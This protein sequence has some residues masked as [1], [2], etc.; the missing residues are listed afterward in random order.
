MGHRVKIRSPHIAMER[1]HLPKVRYEAFAI[2]APFKISPQESISLRYEILGGNGKNL[3]ETVAFPPGQGLLNQTKLFGDPKDL[4][5]TER[6][7]PNPW[8]EVA[9][10]AVGSGGPMVMLMVFMGWLD[11]FRFFRRKKQP[12]QLESPS[13]EGL[14]QSLGVNPPELDPMG[15]KGSPFDV[16]ELPKYQAIAEKEGLSLDLVMARAIK[17][18]SPTEIQGWLQYRFPNDPVA[19]VRWVMRGKLGNAAPVVLH[20]LKEG[21]LNLPDK[22]IDLKDVIRF[23]WEVK[24]RE[25]LGQ[26]EKWHE[27]ILYGED[28]HPTGLTLEHLPGIAFLIGWMG[29]K[30]AAVI[31]QLEDLENGRRSKVFLDDQKLKGRGAKLKMLLRL[32]RITRS[33]EFHLAIADLM[34]F[35][36]SRSENEMHVRLIKYLNSLPPS[37]PADIKFYENALRLKTPAIRQFVR[38]KFFSQYGDTIKIIEDESRWPRSV[39]ELGN[40]IFVA[41]NYAFAKGVDGENLWEFLEDVSRFFDDLTGPQQL[42]LV[43]TYWIVHMQ[44]LKREGMEDVVFYLTKTLLTNPEVDLEAGRLFNSLKREWDKSIPKMETKNGGPYR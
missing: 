26:F 42:E 14:S 1:V 28:L 35:G 39:E 22:P 12:K 36:S 43:T 30:R 4:M 3:P 32:Q 41:K 15:N 2:D 33:L 29:G 9:M 5:P 21:F 23:F 6:T 34:R 11:F 20:Y 38:D 44:A 24:A 37:S 17:D 25:F 40:S 13:Q 8:A 18:S 19:Q 16:G 7:T 27:G 10:M 31:E